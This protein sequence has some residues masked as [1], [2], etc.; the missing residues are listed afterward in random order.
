MLEVSQWSN[1]SIVDA[2]GG[3]ICNA[4]DFV[5]NNVMELMMALDAIHYN[6]DYK[7]QIKHSFMTYQTDRGRNKCEEK[8]ATGFQICFYACEFSCLNCCY[9]LI[10]HYD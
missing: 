6:D 1:I 9:T 10:N 8:V 3:S 2:A 7:V 5:V 4:L